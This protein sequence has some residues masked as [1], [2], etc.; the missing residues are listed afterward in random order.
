MHTHIG[1][2]KSH[3]EAPPNECCVSSPNKQ[4]QAIS[5]DVGIVKEGRKGTNNR[6]IVDVG[7]T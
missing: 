3:L 6:V 2:P 4:V 5:K 7:K 1:P